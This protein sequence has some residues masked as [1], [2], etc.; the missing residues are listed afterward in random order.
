MIKG[1]QGDHFGVFSSI[2]VEIKDR[3]RQRGDTIFSHERREVNVEAHTL[4]RFATSLPVGRHVWFVSPPD[5]LNIP[6][7]L[8]L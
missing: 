4:A 3:A 1:L 5:G 2:L 7:S 8:N 6:V